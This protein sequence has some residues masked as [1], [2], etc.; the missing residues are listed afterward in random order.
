MGGR[1]VFCEL[2]KRDVTLSECRHRIITATD[3]EDFKVC[4][5]CPWGS[6][7]ADSVRIPRSPKGTVRP[8]S[9]D[10]LSGRAD[11]AA[12]EEE[13][14]PL[15]VPKDSPEGFEL[16]RVPDAALWAELHRRHPNL[17]RQF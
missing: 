5:A 10:F 11:T 14:P 15:V 7:L 16:S 4:V 2:L 17:Y 9:F 1:A 6:G 3:R 12:A 8:M 13:E